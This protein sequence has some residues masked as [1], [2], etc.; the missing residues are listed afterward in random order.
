MPARPLTRAQR[1]ENARFLEALSHTGNTRLAAREL[2][3][4]RS[5]FT[6]RRAKHPAFAQDWDA[7]LAAA[8]ARFHLSGGTR[9][10]AQAPRRTKEGLPPKTKGGEPSIIRRSNGKLQLRRAQPGQISMAAEQSFLAALSATANIRLS[11]AAAG[12]A[13]S[14]FY[15]RK[16]TN[17]GFSMEMR[18]ALDMGY[19]R[20]EL[21]LL[22][23][24]APECHMHDEWRL[25]EPP[26]IPPMSAAEAIQLLSLHSS[27]VRS[28]FDL[29]HRGK[30]RAESH[31]QYAKRLGIMWAASQ[32]RLAE[33][34]AVE[35]A[36]QFD[37][38]GTWR[39]PGDW[40][41]AP[42]LPPLDQVT[43]WSKAQ[44]KRKAKAKT[45]DEPPPPPAP[46][47][48]IFGGWTIADW[49]G[50]KRRRG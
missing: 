7:A 28:D 16:A 45:P 10:A 25:H 44:P 43:G 8:H 14:S 35:R 6:K 4:N 40:P 41:Q 17:K 13:H 34:R 39:L 33:A 12:F 2:G 49:D 47:K 32:Y 9:P 42:T 19:D 50:V 18:A 21:A 22:A 29:K 27:T 48:G 11:A 24:H 3:L 23:N 5:T 36:A 37:K 30:R 26:P 20:L 1:F 15:H 38:D 31:A 46:G